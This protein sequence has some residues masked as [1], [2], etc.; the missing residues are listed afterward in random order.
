MLQWPVSSDVLPE[1]SEGLM[2]SGPT[3]GTLPIAMM[4]EEKDQEASNVLQNSRK[5]RDQ[6]PPRSPRKCHTHLYLSGWARDSAPGYPFHEGQAARPFSKREKTLFFMAH[7]WEAV[8][9][10][11][12]LWSRLRAWWPGAEQEVSMA[13]AEGAPPSW[14][15]WCPA[16]LVP[17]AMISELLHHTCPP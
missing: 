14:P 17:Q 2:T 6:R 16:V 5:E 8:F 1:P 7:A 3:E 11:P 9:S 15:W 13:T 4:L 12:L 10:A